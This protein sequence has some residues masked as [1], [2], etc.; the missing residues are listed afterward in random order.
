[1]LHSL[2]KYPINTSERKTYCD[3][4]KRAGKQVPGVGAYNP[5]KLER[6]VLGCVNSK[7]PKYSFVDEARAIGKEVPGAYKP[8]PITLTRSRSAAW[9][10]RHISEK[11]KEMKQREGR[12]DNSPSVHT[13]RPERSIEMTKR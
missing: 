5:K 12:K 9:K 4:L 10:I 2:K 13:Y 3:D 7:L 6:K 11:E 8:V 1:M